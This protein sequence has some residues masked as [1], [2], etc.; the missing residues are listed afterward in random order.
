LHKAFIDVNENG[1][2]AA[3]ATAIVIGITNCVCE[4][5]APKIFDADH[6][7]LFALR[8]AHSGSLLFLGRVA[9]PSKLAADSTA[10]VPEPASVLLLIVGV[11]VVAAKRRRSCN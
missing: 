9:D 2:E 7:F 6:P 5:P 8:D 10:L 3:A 11:F 4:P 1:T